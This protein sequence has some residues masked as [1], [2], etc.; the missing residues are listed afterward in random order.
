MMLLVREF[1][2]RRTVKETMARVK[3]YRVQKTERG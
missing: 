1:L 2:P 3:D